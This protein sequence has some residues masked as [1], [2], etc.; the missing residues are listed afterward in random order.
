M[1]HS[2]ATSRSMLHASC[3][4]PVVP[5]S[6]SVKSQVSAMYGFPVSYVVISLVHLHILRIPLFMPILLGLHQRY[7]QCFLV[8]QHPLSFLFKAQFLADDYSTESRRC[9]R[10]HRWSDARKCSR[11]SI[12]SVL[13]SARFVT[14]CTASIDRLCPPGEKARDSSAGWCFHRHHVKWL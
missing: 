1:R 4:P 13:S 8:A 5:Y 10:R 12:P 2:G 7:L 9:R 3:H 11:G 14:R 6:Q